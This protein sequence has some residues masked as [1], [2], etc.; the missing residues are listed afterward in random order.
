MRIVSLFLL[1]SLSFQSFTATLSER[2]LLMGT[3]VEIKVSGRERKETLHSILRNTRFYMESLAL[4]LSS[5]N[6]Q[7]EIS[8]INEAKANTK[9]EVSPVTSYIIKESLEIS[10][11]TGGS[12]DIT[13][14]PLVKLWGFFKEQRNTPPPSSKIEALL[15]D[16]G[17]Y[18]LKVLPSGEVVKLKDE[19]KITLSGI[20]KGFIVDE[21]IRFLKERKITTALINAGGDLRVYGKRWK[22]GIADPRG[23]RRVIGVITIKEGAVATSG[24]YQR[25]WIYKGKRYH[26]II[27]PRTG[28]PA[29]S[30]IISAT[31][32]S[33]DCMRADALA[34]ALIVKGEKGFS[35]LNDKES[36][37]LIK[38]E[39]GKIQLISSPNMK[40]YFK[41]LR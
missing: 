13:V 2:F 6:S 21:G 20:A 39:N 4:L 17:Y 38:E 40:K 7:S 11:L 28:Y 36:A 37:L 33:P 41:R 31:V 10:R 30:G 9:I 14:F 29:S 34:T 12:F 1:L 19:V 5:Y 25:F 35:W 16:V 27:N 24:D 18:Y 22:I 15:P 26:H 8:R 23:S 3:A 32:I